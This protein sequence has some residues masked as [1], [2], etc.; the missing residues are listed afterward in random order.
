MARKKKCP[1]EGA[2]EWVLTYGDMMSL[3][4]TFFIMLYAM[5]TIDPIKVVTVAEQFAVQ[6]GSSQQ[7]IPVPG[8]QP[9]NNSNKREL[10][11]TGRARRSD[12]F[13]GGNPVLAPKGEYASIQSIRPKRDRIT[14]GVVYFGLG[15]DE[16]DETAREDI[17]LIADQLRGSPYKIQVIGHTSDEP[18]IFANSLHTLGH[19]R[20]A[21]VRN[22]LI[23]LGVDG[24]L[25]Q[26]VSVGPT[27]PVPPTLSTP[28]RNAKEAN[29]FVEVIK[30]LELPERVGE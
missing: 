7:Q 21:N 4:L 20:A 18:G 23:R 2:P 27:E 24:K 19:N 8:T 26:I 29:A 1:P 12:T 28:G 9:P 22:E 13:M 17:R 15:L 10:R 30:L 14:G 3:L 5:S 11:S 6:F 16:L 25:I